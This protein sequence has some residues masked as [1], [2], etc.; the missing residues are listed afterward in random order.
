MPSQLKTHDWE[1]F[2]NNYMYNYRNDRLKIAQELGFSYIS[3]ATV[4]LYRKF[5][6]LNKV[7]KILEITGHTVGR[8]LMAIGEPRRKRGGAPDGRS[9]KE[10]WARKFYD[11]TKFYLGPLCTRKHDWNNTGRSLRHKTK[12]C[13]MCMYIKNQER[14]QKKQLIL[15]RG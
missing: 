1:Q 5:Q 6:S 15:S 4:K 14:Y 12:Y 8:E 3:E 9:V 11:T 2:D 7:G 10:I 13:S